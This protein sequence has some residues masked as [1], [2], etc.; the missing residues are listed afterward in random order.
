MAGM[1]GFSHSCEIIKE[2]FENYKSTINSA[3]FTD[4]EIKRIWDFYVTRSISGR[5]SQSLRLE[6]LGWEIT[7]NRKTGLPALEDSLSVAAGN[8]IFCFVR[9]RTIKDTLGQ[10]D[11]I[12]SH[13]CLQH[14][15]AVMKQE[16]SYSHNENE[17]VF[18]TSNEN[19]IVCLMR[20]IRNA[21]AHGNTYFFNNDNMML[22]D[23]DNASISARIIIPQRALL[24]WIPIIDK[25]N[26]LHCEGEE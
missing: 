24:L 13:I 3:G 25:N 9:A 16:F 6:D 12:N 21:F 5:S 14:P 15:R 11:L 26:T 8:C 19:R 10:M 1:I 2:N 17:E 4:E 18:I 7:Q 20:H 22:E 23:K